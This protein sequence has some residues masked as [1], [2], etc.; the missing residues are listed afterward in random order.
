VSGYAHPVSKEED[1]VLGF[2]RVRLKMGAGDQ[3]VDGAVDP[4]FVFWNRQANVLALQA[5]SIHSRPRRSMGDRR[6]E[7]NQ[8][9]FD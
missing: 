7:V 8:Y 3:S 9:G 2:L 4:E 5:V 1:D 6:D